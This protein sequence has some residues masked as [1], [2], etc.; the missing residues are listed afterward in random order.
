MADKYASCLICPITFP[1]FQDPVVAE[2]GHTYERNAI[3]EWIQRNETS[4]LTREPITIAGLRPNHT[5]KILVLMN[6]GKIYQNIIIS[7]N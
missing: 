7:L 5:V 1:L 3:I 2:D 6:F 4:P